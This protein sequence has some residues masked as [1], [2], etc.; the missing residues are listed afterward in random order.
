MSVSVEDV[1]SLWPESI[2]IPR[3]KTPSRD[4][5]EA[6]IRAGE[7]AIF[8][9][10]VPEEYQKA[11]SLENLVANFG[12]QPVIAHLDFPEDCFGAMP[13]ERRMTVAEFV[14]WM[15]SPERE[16]PCQA[17]NFPVEHL[18][19][20]QGL[21]F[22]YAH[23]ELEA[24]QLWLQSSNTAIGMHLHR[25]AWV[26]GLWG[27]KNVVMIH[28]KYTC[29]GFE[30]IELNPNHV[31]LDPRKP[32]FKKFPELREVVPY[33]GRV[34]PGDLLFIP[35]FMWHFLWSDGPSV[36]AHSD[37]FKVVKVPGQDKFDWPDFTLSLPKWFGPRMAVE[38]ARQFIW[39]G[40]LK[41]PNPPKQHGYEGAPWGAYIWETLVTGQIKEKEQDFE[42]K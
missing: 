16:K 23:P 11:S 28:R 3:V 30:P 31:K 40:A 6:F 24:D 32:D 37:F 13:P 10:I 29:K 34:Q 5:V 20:E 9:D 41:R 33:V 35:E 12:D 15:E 8:E 2:E 36:T 17:I 42:T 18:N 19:P 38:I 1:S 27:S 22:K 25:Q 14:E 4:E 39:Y 7:P 26:G 21:G